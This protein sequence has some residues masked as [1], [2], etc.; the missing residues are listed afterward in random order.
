MSELPEALVPGPCAGE[1][2]ADE[3][4]AGVET[5]DELEQSLLA[6][7]SL[8]EETVAKHRSRLSSRALVTE[9]QVEGNALVTA[10]ADL[11]GQAGSSIDVVL[12]SE[13]AP[14]RAVHSALAD[15]LA[16]EAG[17]VD[18][19]V[20][21]N[22]STLEWGLLPHRARSGTSEVR[23]ARVTALTAVVVDNRV[24]LVSAES[25]AG[26]RASVIRAQSVIQTLRTLFSG[27]WRNAVLV[28]DHLSFGGRARAETTR[29]I[30]E[31]LRGGVTDEVAARDLSVSVRTYR[32]YVA[33][34]MT[35][36]GARSRFQA[37]VRA[38]ELGLLT[39]PQRTAT[40]G[41]ALER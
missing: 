23:V 27:V 31:K 19:R 13:A 2:P 26:R 8:I 38:A 20:L 15:L 18:V 7:R 10:A 35:M 16:D 37:G 4:A 5:R 30:L 33:E 34:I 9:V 14:T 1:T 22:Q 6:V 39:G 36:L 21:C 40:A 41:A 29:R 24:A 12:A 28:P 25:A 3:A 17:D 32:R 11:M